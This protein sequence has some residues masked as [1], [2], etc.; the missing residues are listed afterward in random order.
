MIDYIN[1]HRTQ[2]D[3]F[4]SYAVSVLSYYSATGGLQLALL[5]VCYSCNPLG[6]YMSFRPGV[7]ELYW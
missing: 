6:M 7:Q 1:T 2:R 4:Y 5:P 3:S